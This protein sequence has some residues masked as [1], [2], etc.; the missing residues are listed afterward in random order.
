MLLQKIYFYF[1]CYFSSFESSQLS[2]YKQD[3]S[4]YSLKIMNLSDIPIKIETQEIKQFFKDIESCKKIYT[5]MVF[6]FKPLL[7]KKIWDCQNGISVIFTKE[8]IK[9][10]LSF[11]LIYTRTNKNIANTIF[12]SL[13]YGKYIEIISDFLVIF[14][15][16]LIKNVILKILDEYNKLLDLEY[17]S[18]EDSD[19]QSYIGKKI[20]G[21]INMFS[22]I[23]YSNNFDKMLQF[24]EKI[25]LDYFSY[26]KRSNIIYYYYIYEKIDVFYQNFKFFLLE[27][28][29]K[30]DE[31]IMTIKNFDALIYNNDIKKVS[32]FDEEDMEKLFE[33]LFQTYPIEI[34]FK[35]FYDENNRIIFSINFLYNIFLPDCYRNIHVLIHDDKQNR[36][37]FYQN[38]VID[39]DDLLILKFEKITMQKLLNNF[40]FKKIEIRTHFS[41]VSAN[42]ISFINSLHKIIIN[43]EKPFSYELCRENFFNLNY[44]K[45]F[46]EFFHSLKNQNFS[47]ELADFIIEYNP[48]C[49]KYSNSNTLEYEIGLLIIRCILRSSCQESQKYM[50]DYNEITKLYQETYDL[51]SPQNNRSNLFLVD[52]FDTS[53]EQISFYGKILTHMNL[54]KSEIRTS[55]DDKTFIF[56]S[57]GGIFRNSHSGLLKYSNQLI[58]FGEFEDFYSDTNFG[59]YGII[60]GNFYYFVFF[61]IIDGILDQKCVKIPFFNFE[62]LVIPD[63]RISI[64]TFNLFSILF[65]GFFL[66]EPLNLSIQQNK[67]IFENKSFIFRNVSIK[68]ISIPDDFSSLISLNCEI[69]TQ[70]NEINFINKSENLEVKNLHFELNNFTKKMT[71]DLRIQK[72]KMIRCNSKYDIHIFNIH[73]IDHIIL[74]NFLGC[75]YLDSLKLMSYIESNFSKLNF[76]KNQEL[77]ITS[78]YVENKIYFSFNI[79]NVSIDDCILDCIIFINCISFELKN[80]LGYLSIC[81][82][83]ME[84]KLKKVKLVQNS[85]IKI[86]KLNNIVNLNF[87]NVIFNSD[88]QKLSKNYSNIKLCTID[89]DIDPNLNE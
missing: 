87:Q 53:T 68:I 64:T 13:I 11:G 34:D 4:I 12:R 42:F 3:S 57:N 26:L 8:E 36:I 52:L 32:K 15:N 27:K 38:H 18:K 29:M 65:Y 47:I 58:L 54:K 56:E 55:E 37:I 81:F 63:N 62:K 88:P 25:H 41:R 89:C 60:I 76:F 61:R 33:F 40:R 20:P 82:E 50:R 31:Y 46:L 9:K 17:F 75:V 83:N 2:V 44:I 74:E 39:L 28:N 79:F 5:P 67:I 30:I 77:T 7:Y 80:C 72:L 10:I 21:Y 48:K 73:K 69:K 35:N 19:F 49:H 59:V 1:E 43:L 86:F 24:I 85:S 84:F 51:F 23:I 16:N 45:D 71:I 6:S 66:I 14:R 22:Q 70:E 78:F